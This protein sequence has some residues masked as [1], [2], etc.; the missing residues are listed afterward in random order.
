MRIRPVL[1]MQ[2]GFGLFAAGAY[3]AVDYMTNAAVRGDSYTV[4]TYVSERMSQIR[5]VTGKTP[6]A[7]ALADMFPPAPEGWEV[8][9]YEDADI[10]RITG[11]P[12]APKEKVPAG[13][14]LALSVMPMGAID[15]Q[16]E[17]RTYVSG[18]RTV[19]LG[20]SFRTTAMLDPI[21][22]DAMKRMAELD[23]AAFDLGKDYF[24]TVNGMTFRVADDR[25]NGMV[26]RI[27]GL[28]GHQVEVD[29]VSGEDD[30]TILAILAGLDVA[31]LNGMMD[32]PVAGMGAERAI[33][34]PGAGALP[35]A[36]ATRQ[37]Q[38]EDAARDAS[39]EVSGDAVA[40]GPEPVARPPVRPRAAANC[41][42]A[43]GVKRCKVGD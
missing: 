28:I 25:A 16:T 39:G 38:A 10:T 26:R 21:A 33:L 12:P 3:V 22:N 36:D 37:A 24:A 40:T 42:I 17:Y 23:A 11:K 8:R 5:I 29:V 7:P 1:L 14:V 19:L 27:G 31:G 15:G 35:G 20:I 6:R 32:E 30:E 41:A 4:G 43:Q 34:R 13:P 9:A 18:D 2:I